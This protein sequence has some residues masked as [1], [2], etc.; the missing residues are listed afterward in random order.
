[1]YPSI[2]SR[3]AD[4]TESAI[5]IAVTVGRAAVLAKQRFKEGIHVEGCPGRRVGRNRCKGRM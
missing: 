3:K 5:A 2:L 4:C 1:M